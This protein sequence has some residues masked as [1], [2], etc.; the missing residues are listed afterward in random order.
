LIRGGSFSEVLSPQHSGNEGNY[1]TFKNY[2][3]EVVEI[4]GA[5]LSPAIWIEEKHFIA[6]EGIHVHDTRRWL[7]ALGSNHLLLRNN[8]FERALDEGRSAKTGVFLQRCDYA[9][10][11]NNTMHE[12]TEDNLGLVESNYNLIEDNTITKAY[13]VLWVLKCSNYNIIR[14]NYFHNEDQKIGE[15]YDCVNVGFGEGDYLKFESK[16]DTKYNVVENNIFAYTPSSGDSSPYAGIQ[17]AAQNGIIRN[18][19]FYECTGPALG[20]TIYSDEALNNYSNRIYH[21]VFYDN[22]HGAINVSGST[23]GTFFDQKIKNNI[24]YKNKFI[25][26]DMR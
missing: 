4:T 2:E 13:H 21:N 17:Y 9:I 14:N 19:V 26:N 6:I 16:D 5:S 18:N 8:V 1:I 20:L 11:Q 12:T 7:N 10:I 23:M 15:I 22:K 3:D 24:F 25:Q